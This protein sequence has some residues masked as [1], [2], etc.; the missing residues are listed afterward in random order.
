[1]LH[2][3]TPN[4]P[5]LRVTLVELVLALGVGSGLCAAATPPSFAPSQE[6]VARGPD[7]RAHFDAHG[8]RF[9]AELPSELPLN[10][11]FELLGAR[12]GEV[13]IAFDARVEPAAV[14]SRIAFE[15]GPFTEWY[16]PQ[17]AGIEQSFEF[18]ALPAGVGDLVVSGRLRSALPGV[19]DGAG[20]YFGFPA[21]PGISI[22]AVTGIDAAGR[23]VAGS[24]SLTGDLLELRLP[25]DFVAS[26]ELPLILDPL[27]GAASDGPDANQL[28][29]PDV[30]YDE[31]ADEYLLV[32]ERSLGISG[33]RG[34]YGQRVSSTGQLL[35]AVIDISAPNTPLLRGA[36]RV[37]NVD[38]HNQFVV[39]WEQEVPNGGWEIVVRLVEVGTANLSSVQVIQ[40]STGD[41]DRDMDLGG[42]S[43][44]FIG[45]GECSAMVVF[46]RVANGL[47]TVK[48]ARIHVQ[49][50]FGTTFTIDPSEYLDNPSP[51]LFAAAPTIS[52]TRD[53]NDYYCVVY[54]A[55]STAT[56]SEPNHLRARL[57]GADGDLE[58]LLTLPQVAADLT[59]PQVDGGRPLEGG[60]SRWV[61]AF[62][63]RD[64]PVNGAVAIGVME[65]TPAGTVLNPTLVPSGE[66]QLTAFGS[67]HFRPAVSFT[68]QKF[69]LAAMGRIQ[70]VG[71][72]S[73]EFSVRTFERDAQ[74]GA[75]VQ[76][77][78]PPETII[79]PSAYVP[80]LAL[81]SQ[82]SADSEP[83][84]DKDRGLLLWVGKAEPV[85]VQVDPKLEFSLFQSSLE[86][87]TAEVLGGGCAGGGTPLLSGPPTLGT[88][89]YQ[90]ELAGINQFVSA[91]LLNL[92]FTGGATFT[93]NSCVSLLPDLTVLAVP[94]NKRATIALNL[95][96][97]PS[98]AGTQI[99][100]NWFSL[101]YP[102][103]LCPLFPNVVSSPILRLTFG[104]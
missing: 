96:T 57:L 89:G 62:E 20:L 78:G 47:A 21:G 64:V 103:T 8:L 41:V 12:L 67:N 98:L 95:P 82:W 93:C 58:P 29:S 40:R 104:Q 59:M 54:Q 38:A 56:P 92:D 33:G 39:A 7:Y 72:N 23:S 91:V 45:F 17:D 80:N 66:T 74:P 63:Q 19:T 37:A 84:A 18:E 86:A 79:V 88:F 32:Y 44:N 10:L 101:G 60:S 9:V 28:G 75:W 15:R 35:G 65:L 31:G 83:S 68:G 76:Y 90:L 6:L 70:L 71:S 11:E 25:A 55:R 61:V 51:G 14:G 53:H 99:H 97:T 36:P 49:S 102:V 27:I 46:Q 24:L 100:L 94:N 52:K 48:F 3:S 43:T 5:R 42:S 85:G 1:M 22:G 87:G 30:A 26:A 50:T 69:H 2:L 4:S 16:E 34:I 81:A 13:P 77:I 73:L